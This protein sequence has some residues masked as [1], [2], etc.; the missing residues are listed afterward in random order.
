[1]GYCRGRSIHHSRYLH[2]ESKSGGWTGLEKVVGCKTFTLI[3]L[4]CVS[5]LSKLATSCQHLKSYQNGSKRAAFLRIMLEQNSLPYAISLASWYLETQ[6]VGRKLGK[7]EIWTALEA[8]ASFSAFVSDEQY[9]LGKTGTFSGPQHISKKQLPQ[10]AIVS[11]KCVMVQGAQNK[12]QYIVQTAT[13][14]S[15]VIY[16]TQNLRQGSS[17]AQCLGLCYVT[18]TIHLTLSSSSHFVFSI[19]L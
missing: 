16:H 6:T 14:I 7:E 4:C 8:F 18:D 1:M 2:G 3:V 15:I 13:T 9:N 10:R 5:L 11:I 17:N 19:T 12:T